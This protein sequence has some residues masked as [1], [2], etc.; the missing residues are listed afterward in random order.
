M[1]TRKRTNNKVAD[2]RSVVDLGEALD[3]TAVGA[4]RER[5]LDVLTHNE[6]V[7]LDA[8]ST[9]QVDTAGL[10]VLCSFERSALEQG[11]S[12]TWGGQTKLIGERARL[13][14]LSVLLDLT[15]DIDSGA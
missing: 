5:L 10:Q 12:V 8:T 15:A 2:N 6:P 11:V 13:L 9:K 7:T 4:L 1:G 14:G 3:I